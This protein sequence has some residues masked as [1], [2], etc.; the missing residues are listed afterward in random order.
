MVLITLNQWTLSQTQISVC[1]D[2]VAGHCPF[3]GDPLQHALCLTWAISFTVWASNSN[4]SQLSLKN[5]GQ[6]LLYRLSSC[7]IASYLSK[8][9][10]KQ[11]PAH[12]LS[13][14]MHKYIYQ[15]CSSR[16]H[17][18]VPERCKNFAKAHELL[19][20]RS[21]Q[22]N[23]LTIDLS[24]HHVH[25]ENN[26]LACSK[27]GNYSDFIIVLIQSKCHFIYQDVWERSLTNY[28]TCMHGR[29]CGL[30]SVFGIKI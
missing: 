24:F 13:V 18:A 21:R 12:F 16:V 3:C 29:P 26:D 10:I 6:W 11:Q 19:Q 9:Q 22:C 28:R 30:G 2:K 8:I 5:H 15:A 14:C 1:W 23:V 25:A 7:D 17:C 4:T 20:R 27:C